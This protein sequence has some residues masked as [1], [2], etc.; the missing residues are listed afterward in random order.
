MDKLIKEI[1][2][3]K[4][5]TPSVLVDRLRINGSLARQAL[6]EMEAQGLIKVVSKHKSQLIYTRPTASAGK[7]AS[8]LR[9]RSRT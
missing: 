4:L 7:A 3:A 2:I 1:P 9:V 5:I 8:T 6:A